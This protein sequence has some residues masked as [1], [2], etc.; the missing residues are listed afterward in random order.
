MRLLIML[1]FSV[2]AYGQDWIVPGVGVGQVTK[3]STEASLLAE[4]GTDAVVAD[5][6]IGEG[7]SSEA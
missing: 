1:I 7:C 3:D 2:V 5:V 4:L 6:Y